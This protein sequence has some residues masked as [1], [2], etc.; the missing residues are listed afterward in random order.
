[1]KLKIAIAGVEESK[2]RFKTGASD[3]AALISILTID[4]ATVATSFLESKVRA[5]SGEA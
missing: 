1:V 5:A 2:V 3:V 4:A